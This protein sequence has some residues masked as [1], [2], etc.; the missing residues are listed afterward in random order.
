M[1]EQKKPK[2]EAAK[3]LSKR[4]QAVLSDVE[5]KKAYP[6]ILD[7]LAERWD[8]GKMTRQPGR[9]SVRIEGAAIIVQIECPTEGLQTSF[10][11]G[12]FSSLFEEAEKIL[13]EGKCQ[14][15]LTWDR[16]KNNRPTIETAIQ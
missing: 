10:Q 1:S 9:L 8:A 13:T 3:I 7:L 16:K 14:W 4:V 5:G 11:V 6:N 15:A 2:V 12:S